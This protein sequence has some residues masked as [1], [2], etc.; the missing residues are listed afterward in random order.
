M[1]LRRKL[2]AHGPRVIQTI[3]GRGYLYEAAPPTEVAMSLT[4]RFSALF[5]AA[6]AAGAGWSSR[7]RCTSRRGSTWIAGCASGST[8]RW[9]SWPRRPRSIPRA[10]SGSRG[11]GPRAGPGVRAP[12]GC[13]GWSSTIA[14]GR[15]TDRATW[16]TRTTWR[17]SWPAP[18]G[19]AG[20][21]VGSAGRGL[22]GRPGGPPARGRRR[23][24]ARA[25][26]EPGPRRR[27]PA[28][29]A[30]RSTASWSL[31][32]CA[33]L[34]PT[35]ATLATLALAAGRPERGDLAGR[36]RAV[37][38]ALA[39][40]LRPLTRMV[41]SARGL[42]AA[43]PGW[44]LAEA[45]T[46]DELDDLGRAFNDLLAR[47]HVAFE[48]Q[49]RFSGD[50]SHQLRTPL[51][52]LIGQLQVALRHDRSGEEYRRGADL[53]PG[54]GRAARADR[55][56]PAV[57][58]PRR[59]R[60]RP[61]RRRADGTRTAGSPSTWRAG[62]RPV[63]S[64][65]SSTAPTRRIPCGSGPI[66]RS[67]ASCS[68][69]CWTTPPSTAI[70]R[71]RS[72]SRRVAIGGTA[73]PGRRGSRAG[74]RAGGPAA[75]LRAVL[76]LGP[77]AAAGRL[78]RGAG[79]GRRPPD[80]DRLRRLGGGAERAGAGGAVRGPL[81]VDADARRTGRWACRDRPTPDGRGRI[82]GVIDPRGRGRRDAAG[83]DGSRLR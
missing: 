75:R 3:R 48:R 29:A 49:R 4:G 36:G 61:A 76:P 2:E 68:T 8:R 59:G 79:P 56:G 46:G 7:R 74:D 53:G 18:S 27:R 15:S 34:G 64:P 9:P 13:A 51:T 10:W 60:G 66:P 23:P 14:G 1:E 73:R 71:S 33:P 83:Q 44:R 50:A 45:G 62:R 31:I 11:S 52:V 43:D 22:A 19:R 82:E 72:S 17:R 81:P 26:A 21:A 70:G 20:P 38:R 57:P 40:G 65:R 54:P 35:E 77:G 41:E 25:A 12:T 58:R 67:W 28:V 37:P 5:L 24:P 16:P 69:T 30:V 55:R 32:V 42:D 78:R 47:L 39:P 6:L 80:R 63:A